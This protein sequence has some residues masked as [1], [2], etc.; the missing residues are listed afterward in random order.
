M[1]RPAQRVAAAASAAS[2]FASGTAL[3]ADLPPTWSAT[4]TR[5]KMDDREQWLARVSATPPIE[6]AFR[7]PPALIVRCQNGRPELYAVSSLVL[8]SGRYTA[9]FRVRVDGQPA[10]I[11]NGD[12]SGDHQAVFFPR[13]ADWVKRLAA[14]STLLIEFTPYNRGP[15]VAE[16]SIAGLD[17]HA[18]ALSRVCGVH[19]TPPAPDVT[20]APHAPGGY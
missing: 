7:R 17:R 20:V 16:F 1:I 13:P 8:A 4:T 15:V 14:A 18:E 3:A 11:V 12:I 19:V 9:S 5:S 6:A 2:L 10:E